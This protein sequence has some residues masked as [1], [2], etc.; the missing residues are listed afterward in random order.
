MDVKIENL[1]AL[2]AVMTVKI[3]N[4]DYDGPYNS[5]LKKYKNQIHDDKDISFIYYFS[6]RSL[7]L[8]VNF[9]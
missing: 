8:V 5:S 1:D 3:S 6:I 2:N 7:S 9:K 4:Q